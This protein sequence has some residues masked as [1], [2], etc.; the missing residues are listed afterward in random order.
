MQHK[1]RCGSAYWVGAMSALERRQDSS[2]SSPRVVFGECEGQCTS[3]PPYCS[4]AA[5][6][7]TQPHSTHCTWPGGGNAIGGIGL[8]GGH[9]RGRMGKCVGGNTC[10]HAQMITRA[11]RRA[12]SA[13]APLDSSSLIA[14]EYGPAVSKHTSAE[15]A[16][17]SGIA[18]WWR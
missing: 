18:Y 8:A 9:T 12:C 14:E 11:Q 16:S 13:I 1:G 17:P 7:G 5:S 6:W 4:T 2:A 15:F 10:E 3:E